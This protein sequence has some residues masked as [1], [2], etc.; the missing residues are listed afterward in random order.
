L[1][2]EDRTV[3]CRPEWRGGHLPAVTWGELFEAAERFAI[4]ADEIQTMLDEL[5]EGDDETA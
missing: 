1:S 2:D 4:D 5:R 3:P